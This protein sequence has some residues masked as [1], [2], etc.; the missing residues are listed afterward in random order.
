MIP[1]EKKSEPNE[2]I[3]HKKQIQATFQNLPTATKNTIRTQ[4]IEEQGYLCAYCMQRI[5]NDGQKT[6]IEHWQCQDNYPEQQLD[7]SNMLLAC[8]GNEGCDSEDQHCDTRK[9][10]QE[11]HCNPA[12]TEH[13]Y[14]LK[15]LS[16]PL[17]GTIKSSD[18]V[19]DNDLNKVLNL[20][21]SRLKRTRYEVLQNLMKGL[22][23]NKG[24]RTSSE[25]QRYL[26]KWQQKDETGKYRAY[27]G[28]VISYLK[29]KL[30]SKR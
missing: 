30:K 16:Y 26:D 27:C 2:L 15:T 13:Q 17:N 24:S 5:E 23:I 12:K 29:K 14:L 1:I 28:I 3:F 9:G 21:Y 8:V 11:L 22:N 20:N 4:L 18:T 10:N 19:L 7:Y 6:K 25:I